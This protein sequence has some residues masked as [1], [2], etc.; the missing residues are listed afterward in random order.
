MNHMQGVLVMYQAV[1]SLVC[2]KGAQEQQRE[3]GPQL[4]LKAPPQLGLQQHCCE[5]LGRRSKGL[6]IGRHAV[7]QQ[8]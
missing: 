4:S 5:E 2:L 1:T 3:E 6:V 8:R 7:P